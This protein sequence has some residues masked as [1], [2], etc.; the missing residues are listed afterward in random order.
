MAGLGEAFRRIRDAN[1]DATARAFR[2]L[3]AKTLGATSPPVVND[4]RETVQAGEVV[5]RRGRAR[6]EPPAQTALPD[7]QTPPVRHARPSDSMLDEMAGDDPRRLLPAPEFDPA[8]RKSGFP[9]Y[10]SPRRSYVNR[11]AASADFYMRLGRP[12]QTTPGQRLP[13]IGWE[14][15]REAWLARQDEKD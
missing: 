10:V 7:V 8:R 15:A 13:P 4:S 2:E 11:R 6:P 9:P 12:E 5:D 3:K 1:Q 14:I